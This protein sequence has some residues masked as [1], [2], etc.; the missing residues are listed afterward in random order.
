MH[1]LCLHVRYFSSLVLPFR[2][3]SFAEGSFDL[4]LV[5]GNLVG[6][7]CR[8]ESGSEGPEIWS[9]MNY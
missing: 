5:G 6:D 7:S 8:V 3:F 9:S 2:S 1:P 4:V